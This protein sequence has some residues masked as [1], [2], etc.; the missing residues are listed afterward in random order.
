M[1][2]TDVHDTVPPASP[3]P[4]HVLRRVRTGRVGAGVAGGLGRYFNVDPVLFRV[5][6]ATSAFFGG[7]GILA[8]LLAWAAI[9]EEGTERAPIDGWMAALRRRRIPVWVVVAIAGL[10]L[11][12]LAF[13]WWVPGPF[14]VVLV[15]T[16]LLVAFHGRRQWQ[17]GMHGDP[18][19]GAAPPPVAPDG[20][21]NLTK[22]T[23]DAGPDTGRPGWVDDAYAWFRESRAAARERKRR[24]RPVELATLVVLAITLATLALVDSVT[25]IP[26]QTYFW[27]SVGIIVAGL[28]VG[29]V[30]RRFPAAISFLLPP[31][32]VGVLA[33][34]GSHASFH[35]G[36]GKRT[37]TPTV[38]PSSQYRLAFGQGILDL[39]SLPTQ[40]EAKTVRITAGA[41]QVR[42]IVPKRANVTVEANVHIGQIEVHNG[43]GDNQQ[44]TGDGG[45]GVNR[46]VAPPTNAAGA[47]LTISIHLAD[48]QIDIDRR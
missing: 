23:P 43:L 19:G 6:F 42:L 21:V 25:G 20:T 2:T 45:V 46:T 31:L 48:G 41:G 18:H 13:S 33:F 28:L 1:T 4:T 14:F 17:S 11:C 22:T 32:V 34:A 9:P 10:L 24:A 36:M 5:L 37:W 8:Y 44:R 47:P 15:I 30:I 3:G 16:I 29:A 38:T 35:D 39:R 26:I 40:T 27:T 12:T 7:A